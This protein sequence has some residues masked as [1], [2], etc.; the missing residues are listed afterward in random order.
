MFAVVSAVDYGILLGYLA[1]MVL[2]GLYFAGKQTSTD[3][4]FLG[5]RS[6][7]WMPLGVSLLATLL[8]ALS[9]TG[10]PGQAY[11]VGLA[12]L[13]MPLAVWLTFPIIA[14][15]VLPIY[16]GLSLSSV[17][18]YLEYRFDSRVRV[19]ASLLFIAWR[20]L[21]LGGVIF[22]P[23]KLL[24]IATGWNIPDWPLLVTLGIVTTIYTFLGGM[25][26]VI[27]T[28]VI[29]AVVMFIGTLVIIVSV[30]MTL[31][32]GTQEVMKT[33]AKMG[34]L[35]LG[36]FQFS[37][38]N[39]WCVW[40]FLLHYFLAMLSFY[41]ADQI[42]AQR[43]L[44]SRSTEHSQR[45]FLLNCFGVSLLM[46]LL[47]YVGLCLL[48]FYQT[49]PRAMR[50][51]W[52]ANLDTITQQS[53]TREETRTARRTNRVT[54]EEELDPTSGTPLLPFRR[55]EK[56]IALDTIDELVSEQRI[57]MPNDK[58]PFASADELVDSSTGELMVEQLAMRKPSTGEIIVH[59]QAPEEMLP[60]YVS[61]Q[62]AMGA[63]GLILA[64]ILA[65][66]MSSIDS[67]LNSICSLLVLD[68][69]RRYGI[70]RSWLAR[71]LQKEE[72]DLNE[73]D[74]LLLAQ[75]LTLVIGVGATLAAIVLS[76]MNEVF[77]IMIA[78]VNTLGAPLLAV[79]LLGMFT[80]RA[81]GTSMLLVMTVGTLFTLWLMGV[82]QWPWLAWTWPFA[83]RLDDIWTV[84]FGT[85]F[86]LLLG[87]LSSF[88]VGQTKSKTDLRGL[89]FRVGTPGVRAVD[90]EMIVLEN[91]LA[92]PSGDRWK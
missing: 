29:Q 90:E 5:S 42:T 38:T 50:P 14:G 65:A 19:V 47:T 26:A 80:R 12:I 36:E 57:L 87:Y 48:T 53:I 20:M 67:G 60:Q 9:Y 3:E 25:K 51:E 32:G 77:S 7:S 74:E 61:D 84:T 34:R 44:S 59:R 79:F 6:F 82:N 63:A 27:W 92:E 70:G 40:G 54:G 39:R 81:T 85:I 75:P 91:P 49:H 72:A 17:Y 55:S 71:R 23:C 78:V 15:V 11:Q 16:R 33:A 18:E 2:L 13:L 31:D 8:S 22:A 45:S 30:W 62:L 89:V 1:L 64:A 73:A 41:I 88:V 69:H 46:C 83:T 24:L 35:S 37:W 58:R 10:F 76:Q 68:F 56:S 43:F 4:Y 28:D 21:W 66:S 86:S 52:V